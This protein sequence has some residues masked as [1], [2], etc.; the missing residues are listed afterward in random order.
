MSAP[1]QRSSFVFSTKRGVDMRG[2]GGGRI[3]FHLSDYDETQIWSLPEGRKLGGIPGPTAGLELS[4][5]GKAMATYEDLSRGGKRNG[6][7]RIVVWDVDRV[8]KVSQAEVKLDG[9]PSEL[10]FDNAGNT[11]A[12]CNRKGCAIMKRRR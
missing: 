12:V 6:R 2:M 8:R 3:A 1:A 5:D 9:D 7:F 4:P 10:R 11:L